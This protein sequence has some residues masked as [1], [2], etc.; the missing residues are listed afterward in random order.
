MPATRS[1]VVNRQWS[2]VNRSPNF[3]RAMSRHQEQGL[4]ASWRHPRCFWNLDSKNEVTISKEYHMYSLENIA[5]FAAIPV[6]CPST[7]PPFCNL[8]LHFHVYSCQQP[9]AHILGNRPGCL[10]L[11]A[12][13][14]LRPS[15]PCRRVVE[16][17]RPPSDSFFAP[18]RIASLSSCNPL[19]L[20]L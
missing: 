6:P 5:G 10:S 1:S 11:S 13:G 12:A 7:H 4:S 9:T 14:V 2:E 17:C 18:L 20:L 8:P 16:P 3:R 19:S 15:H